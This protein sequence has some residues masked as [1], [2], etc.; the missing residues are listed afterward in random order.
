M[1]RQTEV[2]TFMGLPFSMVQRRV[3]L[4]PMPW[5][6]S[7]K[8]GSTT[9]GTEDQTEQQMRMLSGC[10]HLT[11][12]GHGTAS[13]KTGIY[14]FQE[15]IYFLARARFLQNKSSNICLI[16]PSDWAGS[17]SLP[18]IRSEGPLASIHP[19]VGCCLEQLRSPTHSC[20][21]CNSSS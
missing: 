2:A 18:F 14:D 21:K 9:G 1:K 6:T 17:T 15:D 19:T 20:K 3:M 12:H 8:A 7:W 4:R 10:S 5:R 11:Q 13:E 16:A